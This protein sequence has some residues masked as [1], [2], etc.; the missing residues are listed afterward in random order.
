[1]QENVGDPYGGTLEVYE[2]CFEKI[3]SAVDIIIENLIEKL[4]YECN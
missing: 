1:M 2:K 3:K 4:K